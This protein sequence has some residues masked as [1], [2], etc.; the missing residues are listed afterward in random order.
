VS[1]EIAM[2]R[3][4]FNTFA[5]LER[6]MDV[7]R[8]LRAETLAGGGWIFRI[9]VGAVARLQRKPLRPTAPRGVTRAAADT[10]SRA[11]RLSEA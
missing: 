1:K 8:Q 4:H 9:F 10:T 11:H 5:E 6:Q 7:A 3:K 2:T